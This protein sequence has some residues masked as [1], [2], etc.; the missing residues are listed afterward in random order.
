MI[1]EKE[2][3]GYRFVT[4]SLSGTTQHEIIKRA[5]Y[6]P[7][8]VSFPC[9]SSDT[10]LPPRDDKP[11]ELPLTTVQ[12]KLF[13]VQPETNKWTRIESNEYNTKPVLCDRC[14][15]EFSTEEDLRFHRNSSDTCVKPFACFFC[16]FSTDSC[17]ILKLHLAFEH[18]CR[19]PYTCY[20]CSHLTGD[21][22]SMRKHIKTIHLSVGVTVSDKG[23]HAVDARPDKSIKINTLTDSSANLN[24]E[25]FNKLFS[26]KLKSK[27][28]MESIKTKDII[29]D[30]L[31]TIL[32][33]PNLDLLINK[34]NS[35]NR[36]V[37]STRGAAGIGK[38]R[39]R[40]YDSR[41]RLAAVTKPKSPYICFYCSYRNLSKQ[42]IKVHLKLKHFR[43]ENGYGDDSHVECKSL[44]QTS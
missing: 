6:D 22:S 21:L 2:S 36:S 34:N 23:R 30:R 10:E 37:V 31:Q 25:I 26:S 12:Q 3:L 28:T 1:N 4:D 43:T 41:I 33:K 13:P 18:N 38:S 7:E 39:T 24:K 14:N 17:S 11:T 27:L 40:R 16:S 19:E 35:R 32:N 42:S 9:S 20:H 8:E 44:T 5:L 29:K 15:C